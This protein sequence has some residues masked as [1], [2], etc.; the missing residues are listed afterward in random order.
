MRGDAASSAAPKRSSTTTSP[1][2]V[3]KAPAS[4]SDTPPGARHTPVWFG[5]STT[6]SGG[7][8]T[9]AKTWAA[10]SPEYG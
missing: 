1:R 5:A 9:R 3:R 6:T 7:I 4:H 8:S 2:G 10:V